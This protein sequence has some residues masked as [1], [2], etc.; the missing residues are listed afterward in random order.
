MLTCVKDRHWP[1][2]M[3]N[4]RTK[5]CWHVKMASGLLACQMT[6]P[7]HADTCQ[8]L[9]AGP[10][11]P[12]YSERVSIMVSMFLGNSRWVWTSLEKT[13]TNKLYYLRGVVIRVFDKGTLGYLAFVQEHF[14]RIVPTFPWFCLIFIFINRTSVED[15][16]PNWISIEDLCG[17]EPVLW[18][19]IWIH[20]G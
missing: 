9:T 10:C 11:F 13:C 7:R 6:E 20:T 15:P 14:F 19:W 3:S 12:K 18:I 1:T 17:S 16:D 8:E 2:G 5:A 4:D